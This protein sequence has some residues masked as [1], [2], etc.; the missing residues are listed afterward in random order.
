MNKTALP[1]AGD[2]N[3]FWE[4]SSLR[5][6]KE[7][8]WSKRRILDVMQ[9]YVARGKYALDA[10]CGSGFFS[11]YFCDSGMRTT[12]LD[13]SSQALALTKEKTR[14]RSQVIQADL[15]NPDLTN[16]IQERFDLIFSDGLLE[17]FEPDDQNLIL[18]NLKRL[19]KEEGVLITVVPNRW[20]PWELIRPLWMPGI[21]EKPFT[22][23][24]LRN[25]H[26]R[27]AL[28][29]LAQGGINTLPL[30]FSGDL[31]FGA[32]FGMLLYV[33]TKK[34]EIAIR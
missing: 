12:S 25:L 11:A 19:L 18:L 29:I 8:S 28:T 34:N 4:Q 27:N 23:K 31:L 16:V 33:I 2:W 13:Y 10:G 17:H 20:S 21:Q 6:P 15:L 14:G 1:A 24:E 26:E 32:T 22:L 3:T 30:R 9:P 7:A 5:I